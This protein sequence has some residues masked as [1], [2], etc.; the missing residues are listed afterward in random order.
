MFHRPIS[1]CA[2]C[3][4][5]VRCLDSRLVHCRAHKIHLVSVT[6]SA[7]SLRLL[8]VVLIGLLSLAADRNGQRLYSVSIESSARVGVIRVLL[9]PRNWPDGDLRSRAPA[10]AT[11]RGV[12]HMASG[13]SGW[14][15][16]GIWR[17]SCGHAVSFLAGQL[18]GGLLMWL[19]IVAGSVVS[20]N[21]QQ[22]VV[23]VACLLILRYTRLNR[24]C[25]SSRHRGELT[26]Q[27]SV[28]DVVLTV[29]AGLCDCPE[30]RRC[31]FV[32]LSRLVIS[33][34]LSTADSV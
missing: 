34:W 5:G 31:S 15:L 33:A 13:C 20:V 2:E 7:V 21:S 17:R 29:A 11:R 9:S 22:L 24:P 32:L 19:V 30:C 23:I 4:G 25:G 27:L 10:I 3:P 14:R 26:S 12:Y 8:S 1:Y 6:W 28:G 16:H 18:S